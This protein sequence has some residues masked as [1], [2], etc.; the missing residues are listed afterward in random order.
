VHGPAAAVP[1][2]GAVRT[3]RG[4][5][6]GE[7]GRRLGNVCY[8]CQEA[9]AEAHRWAHSEKRISFLAET[10]PK[11]RFLWSFHLLSHHTT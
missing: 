7:C 4:R 10:L 3:G 11:L 6:G 9:E 8:H 5:E 2:G 1:R